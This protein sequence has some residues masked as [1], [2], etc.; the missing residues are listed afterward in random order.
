MDRLKN[1]KVYIGTKIVEA[2]QMTGKEFY[3]KYGH[4]ETLP[5]EEGYAVHYASGYLSWS[6]KKEFE[7]AYRPITE[8]ESAVVDERN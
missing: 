8:E 2:Q 7:I 3:E 1:G 6:P 4:Q 5:D